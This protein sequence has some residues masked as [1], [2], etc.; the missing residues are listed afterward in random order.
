MRPLRL[1]SMGPV[2]NISGGV[3][4]TRSRGSRL[5]LFACRRR[6]PG[7][8]CSGR[9]PGPPGGRPPLV[10]GGAGTGPCERRRR[11]SWAGR[12][13]GPPGALAV[14]GEAERGAGP[15][16]ASGQKRG[17]PVTWVRRL[18]SGGSGPGP[19]MVA[20]LARRTQAR[21]IA[22]HAAGRR[23][24]HPGAWL[25]WSWAGGGVTIPAHPELGAFVR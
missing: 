10:M 21:L 8:V 9:R 18:R 25:P 22:C 14:V 12:E 19:G 20:S 5:R 23:P 17:R 2:D 7:P 16:C 4:S 11:W 3:L 24:D 6:T 13:A 1:G 15:S